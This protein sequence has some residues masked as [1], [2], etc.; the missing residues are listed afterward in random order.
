MWR[1]KIDTQPQ[2]NSV[3]TKEADVMAFNEFRTIDASMVEPS[4]KS[5]QKK[6][7]PWENSKTRDIERRLGVQ[8]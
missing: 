1:N 8:R 5:K 6:I 2:K 3:M 7:M 4:D